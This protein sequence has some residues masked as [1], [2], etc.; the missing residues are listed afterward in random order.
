MKTRTVAVVALAIVLV[1]GVTL[2]VAIRLYP[3]PQSPGISE[4]VSSNGTQT[5]QELENLGNRIWIADL[6]FPPNLGW[7][8]DWQDFGAGPHL[9]SITRVNTTTVAIVAQSGGILAYSSPTLG[10]FEI[11]LSKNYSQN[12][13]S[14]GLIAGDVVTFRGVAPAKSMVLNTPTYGEVEVDTIFCNAT[15]NRDG[16]VFH[17]FGTWGYSTGQKFSDPSP[18]T[19]DSVSGWVETPRFVLTF[20]NQYEWDSYSGQ[21]FWTGNQT[22]EAVLVNAVDTS[23]TCTG[24]SLTLSSSR[25][26]VSIAIPSVKLLLGTPCS[27]S[28]GTVN[29]SFGPVSSNQGNGWAFLGVTK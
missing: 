1:A 21:L 29:E 19:T 18:G 3:T 27:G 10:R 7:S 16:K 11:I 9:D 26:T 5:S 12:N 22:S 23:Q 24:Y 14:P 28:S 6:V 13:F 8:S 17:G 25:G 20:A 15:L 4:T 2:F